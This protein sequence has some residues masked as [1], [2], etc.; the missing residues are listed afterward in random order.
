MRRVGLHPLSAYFF[1][2]IAFEE[3][4]DTEV[5]Q[6]PEVEEVTP[7]AFIPDCLEYVTGTDE[8]SKLDSHISAVASRKVN[9]DAVL[10]HHL[11]NAVTSSR[12]FST[13]FRSSAFVSRGR[14]SLISLKAIEIDCVRNVMNSVTHR[15]FGHWLRDGI[16]TSKIDPENR[17]LILRHQ[18]N[19]AHCKEYEDIFSVSPIEDNIYLARNLII[20]T[21]HSQGS[22]K[23]ARYKI[24]RRM[25]ADRFPPLGL[26]P[27]IYLKRGSGGARRTLLNEEA[28]IANLSA[29]GWTVLDPDNLSASEI[30]RQL[31]GAREV[32]SIEGSHLNHS[33]FSIARG[34]ILTILMPS[35]RFT[36]QFVGLCRANDLIPAIVV[37]IGNGRGEYVVNIDDILF[38][39]D[40]A[41]T[42]SSLMTHHLA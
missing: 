39:L 5:L 19:W 9:H 34:G 35:D 11:R 24:M 10:R 27:R 3:K 23:R 6:N 17:C 28:V 14:R 29:R 21:D 16:A 25:L 32:I 7:P 20:Y 33:L 38:T 12:G 2:K 42:Q 8:H 31:S 36:S 4:V 15:Y 26:E 18:E 13:W 40:L 22:H 41:R 1:E 30:Q 37:M